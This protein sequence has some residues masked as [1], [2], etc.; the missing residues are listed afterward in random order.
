MFKL[1]FAKG[2]AR[3][4]LVV[5]S[6]LVAWAAL[7]PS[8]ANAVVVTG[9]SGFPGTAG[10]PA[11]VV[12]PPGSSC[13]ST[14][15]ICNLELQPWITSSART[16]YESPQYKTRDQRVC[17]KHRLFGYI[18]SSY[19]YYPA[20]V[21]NPPRWTAAPEQQHVACGVIRAAESSIRD[22]GIRFPVQW[23]S[24]YGI[25][26]LVTWSLTNGAPIGAKTYDYTSANDYFC[27]NV[28]CQRIDEGIGAYVQ[29]MS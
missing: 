27:R 23:N 29:P 21:Y 14:G 4:T 13:N 15:T 7:N 5:G 20:F 22:G 1:R 25:D 18:N 17:I 24:K 19:I 6:V 16:I 8:P 26:V 3:V 2:L 11:V 28:W 10:I 9:R 12:D